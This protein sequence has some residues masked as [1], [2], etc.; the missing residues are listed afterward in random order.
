M[1]TLLTIER[2]RQQLKVDDDGEDELIFGL[3]TAATRAVE[4][5]TGCTFAAGGNAFAP[6]DVDVAAQAALM[7]I[8]TW[9]D[10]RD[11]N[12][13]SSSA[14]ELPLAVTWLLWPIKRL[15]V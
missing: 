11:G 15:S 7:L 8:T 3:M 10:N 14:G 13:T 12:T 9:F 4:V 2:V 6:E 1:A 5:H